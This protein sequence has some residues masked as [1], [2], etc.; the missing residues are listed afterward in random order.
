MDRI[1]RVRQVMFGNYGMPEGSNTL[2]DPLTPP[3]GQSRAGN[4]NHGNTFFSYDSQVLAIYRRYNNLERYG[5][6]QTRAVIDWRATQIAGNGVNAQSAADDPEIRDRTNEFIEKFL[7]A[8]KLNG[9]RFWTWARDAEMEGKSLMILRPKMYDGEWCI[10][11]RNVPWIRWNYEIETDAKDVEIYKS[12]TIQQG[13]SKPEKINADRFVYVKIAG[14][15]ASKMEYHINQTPP[16]IA[17]VLWHI[18]NIDRALSDLRCNN[19][20]F[21]FPKLVGTTPDE[22]SA[23]MLRTMLFGQSQRGATTASIETDAG[24]FYI[25]HGDMKFIEPSGVAVNSLTTEINTIAKIIS[26]E[27][28]IP[29]HYLGFTDLMSNRATAEDLAELV[30]ATTAHERESWKEAIEDL[31]KKAIY[32]YM[33]R[34][35]EI[36]DAECIEVSLPV[37]MMSQ[38]NQIASV[39]MPLQESKII[40]KQTLRERIP[41]IDPEVE[42]ERIEEE[43]SSKQNEAAQLADIMTQNMRQNVMDTERQQVDTEEAINEDNSAL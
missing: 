33:D 35:G 42:K 30:N 21:A 16:R 13:N 11:A 12:A 39:F 43:E 2:I 24:E 34:T 29:I 40:S 15:T 9:Q 1:R 37:V 22:A 31:I 4:S 41:G 6:T 27:T 28:G 3:V 23:N 20:L 5:C 32:L 19:H 17:N 8:N 38:V 25:L 18:D 14:A 26:G 10:E 7:N 36:L